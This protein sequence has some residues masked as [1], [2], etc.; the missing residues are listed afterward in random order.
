MKMEATIEAQR[1]QLNKLELEKEIS[2]LK[3]KLQ[4][5]DSAGQCSQDQ[6]SVPPETHSANTRVSPPRSTAQHCHSSSSSSTTAPS[7]PEGVLTLP[8]LASAPEFV[9]ASSV[10][11]TSQQPDRLILQHNSS[12]M[13]QQL[14]GNSTTGVAQASLH[15]KPFQQSFSTPAHLPAVN[16]MSASTQAPYYP[17][18]LQQSLPAPVCSPTVDSTTALAQALQDTMTLNRL[19]VPKPSVFT[20]DPLQFVEWQASFTALIDQRGISTS[21]KFHYL[22]QYLG[23]EAREVVEGTF[24]RTDDNAYAQAWEKLRKRYGQPFVVQR[25]FRKKIKLWPKIGPKDYIGVRRFSDFLNSCCDAIPF[26]PSLEILNDCKENQKILQKLPDWITSHWNRAVSAALEKTGCYPSFATF[27]SF[28]AK[29]AEIA[30]NPISSQ[31]ALRTLETECSI[32]EKKSNVRTLSTSTTKSSGPNVDSLQD[33]SPSS[34]HQVTPA[35]ATKSTRKSVFCHFCKG[36]HSIHHC[37]TF[38]KEKI[39]DRKSFIIKNNLCFGCLRKGHSSKGCQHQSTCATCQK[40]HPTLLHGDLRSTP[41][42]KGEEETIKNSHKEVLPEGNETAPSSVSHHTN[43]GEGGSTS[44][45]VPV[46]VSA[47]DQPN[48]EVLVY[49]LLDT[50]SDTSFVLEDTA[51]ALSAQKTPVQLKLSTMTSTECVIRCNAVRGIQVRGFSSHTYVPISCAYTKDYIPVE[52]THIPTSETAMAWQHLQCIASELQPLQNCEVGLLIGYDTPQ[53][54]IPR[55]A[56]VGNNSEPY[57]VKTDLGWSIVGCT[58]RFDKVS[59]IVHRTSARESPSISPKDVLKVLESDFTDTGDEILVSQDDIQ[60]VK[61]MERGICHKTDGHYEMPLPFKSRPSL[62]NNRKL[63]EIRLG[64][65]KRKLTVNPEYRQHYV[66]F[67]EE[68]LKRGDAEAVSSQGTNGEVWYIPHHGVYHPKKPKKIRV[69]FDCSAKFKGSSLNEHLLTG[70]DM[71]NELI[72]VLMRFR[73]HS[74]A[75]LCDVERMFHQFH[76]SEPDRDYLRFLWWADGDM[77]QEPQ[78]FR[79]KVHLFGAASSPGCANYGFRSLAKEYEVQYPMASKFICQNFYVDDGVT[80]VQN[81]D[82]AIRLV[83]E[84]MELCDKGGLRLHKFISN[85]TRVLRNIPA[86]ERASAVKEVDLSVNALPMETALGIKWSI[87]KDVFTFSQPPLQQPPTRRGILSAVASLFDPLGFLAPYILKGKRI[88]QEMC[89]RGVGWDDALLDELRREWEAWKNDQGIL[90]QVKISRCYYPTG[91]DVAQIEL[92]HFSDASTTGYGQCSYVRFISTDGRVHCCLVAGKSRVAPTKVTT[93]PRLELTAAVVSVKVSC[94]L[95]RE[96]DYRNATEFF[97]TDSKV[98]FGYIHNEARRFHTFVSNR[99][100]FIRDKTTLDQWSYV[101]TEQN[102]ADHASRGL[103]VNELCNSTWLRGPSFLWSKQLPIPESFTVDLAIGDPE[104]RSAQAFAVNVHSSFSVADCLSKFSC[105]SLAVKAIARL[106]RLA[107][108]V[109]GDGPTSVAEQ[110]NA[111][112]FIIKEV[113]KT[114]FT[115]ESQG[116][117]K[118]S[119]SLLT[120]NP[121]VDSQGV[122]R[123][124]GRLEESTL[125]EEI[126]HPSI[127]PKNHPMTTLIIAHFYAKVKHQGRGMTI[128]EIRAHGLWIIGMSKAVASYIHNCVTCRKKRRPTEE[129]KMANLPESRMEDTPP[130]TFSGMDCFGPFVIKERRKELK[131]YGL[132]FT[133]MASRAVHI[134]MLDDLSTDAFINALRCF[135]AI[136]GR[137]QVLRSDQGTNFLGAKNEFEKEMQELDMTRLRTFMVDR[138]CDFVMNAPHSSHTGGVWERQIRTARSILSSLL[139]ESKGRL[140]VSSLRTFFYEVMYIMNSRPLT[141]DTSGDP[142]NLEPLTPNHVLTMKANIAYPPP[143]QFAKEDVYIRK[144]WKRVQYL[145]EQF[146]SR[147]KE[148]LSLLNKRQKWCTPRRNIQLGDIVII[149]DKGSLR[150]KWP[151]AKVIEVTKGR[152]GLVRRAKVQLGTSRLDNKGETHL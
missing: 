20:G 51:A 67:M 64:H 75:I 103:T 5:Y 114:V 108:R 95:K 142:M 118:R 46:W 111:E 69:V 129:Q 135:I 40:R 89:R 125:P 85:D 55:E 65:L 59:G 127:I 119:S 58:P 100:Q 144:R 76:V 63:A 1:A 80:S 43:I 66:G 149:H 147:R 38:L 86:S 133:C 131:C 88:L 45:I 123:V 50:Q 30:C 137:V 3:A 74:I 70:P 115:E 102:P 136:R 151:L 27:S 8:L 57:G 122:L 33:S 10:H 71:T 15:A 145:A 61:I 42:P 19:P 6:H 68:M 124:G 126:K 28:L 148:Y 117:C 83:Q 132:L 107:S 25:A 48:Q 120:F 47:V 13:S 7:T 79:M 106:K 34:D 16:S 14:P 22:K 37:K 81:I 110:R 152:D 96:L 35:A 62:P 91:F 93:I 12:N 18:P 128:N 87:D 53:A 84:A 32:R 39:E 90:H 36:E 138:Q 60:F 121:F 26:V 52:K 146:W 150:S 140:D 49:A 113:Q 24:F 92:H 21:Q 56:I 78:D 73:K 98:V 109:R 112:M 143:G 29:E 82:D 54:L 99:I 2:M 101:P 94:L 41:S 134:E 130:F 104:V 31:L 23:G 17:R 4:A 105:W 44:M 139:H 11:P 9:P 77:S 72:G 116:V 141:A 97:W